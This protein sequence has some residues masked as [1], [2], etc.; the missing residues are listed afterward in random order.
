[1]EGLDFHDE[2]SFLKYLDA[3][4]EMKRLENQKK[5]LSKAWWTLELCFPF[6]LIIQYL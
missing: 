5:Y 3:S 1:M 6:E 4:T 2:E